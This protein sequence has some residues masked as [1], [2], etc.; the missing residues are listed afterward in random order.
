[1]SL[2]V[3]I[4]AGGEGKRM[5]SDTPKVLHLFRGRPMLVWIVEAAMAL[6]PRS[7]VI[8]TGRFHDQIIQKLGEYVD[9]FG[10]IFIQQREPLGTGDAMSYCID[11]YEDTDNVLILN[12]DTPLVTKE[13]LDR[14]VKSCSKTCAC[15]VLSMMLANPTGYGRMIISEGILERIVEERDATKEEKTINQVNSGI[16][17]VRGSV[18]RR[19]I[20]MITNQNEQKEFYLTDMIQL[21]YEYPVSIRVMTVLAEDSNPLRGINTPE[22]LAEI[23]A[24]S[25]RAIVF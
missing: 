18:L 21:I 19:Y 3:T 16:Y 22:E 4:L 9:I 15:V 13:I 11:Y 25:K 12:G 24:V 14:F 8:V 23:E 6:S 5:R 10:I 17:M 1:M 2:V 7:I 20:P